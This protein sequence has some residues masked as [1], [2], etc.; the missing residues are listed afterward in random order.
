MGGGVALGL[1]LQA[2]GCLATTAFFVFVAV[3]H[4]IQ[5]SPQINWHVGTNWHVADVAVSAVANASFNISRAVRPAS[6]TCLIM[7]IA[8]GQNIAVGSTGS[9]SR[10]ALSSGC[11]W[12]VTTIDG[13]HKPDKA[14]P[15]NSPSFLI[16]L[17]RHEETS[18]SFFI[19]CA[20]HSSDSCWTKCHLYRDNIAAW[21]VSSELPW[22]HAS[23][24]ESHP[25]YCS[26][27]S[28]FYLA[29]DLSGQTPEPCPQTVVAHSCG[30]AFDLSLPWT[31]YTFMVPPR[32]GHTF[33]HG[34]NIMQEDAGCT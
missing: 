4:H 18:R 34:G 31:S 26:S 32:N 6:C 15:A 17:G 24:P 7:A 9:L 30:H 21:P 33:S 28:G 22:R 19:S 25:L 13:D 14:L 3:P 29:P 20:S 16:S 8:S 2:L 1:G 12:T 10:H 11:N 23:S 27:C 5:L